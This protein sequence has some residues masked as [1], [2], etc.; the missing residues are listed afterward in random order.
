ML[1]AKDEND[2]EKELLTNE[3]MAFL[4]KLHRRFEKGMRALHEKQEWRASIERKHFLQETKH[5]REGRWNIKPV[6]ADLQDRRVVVSHSAIDQEKVLSVIK[7]GASLFTADFTSN[8]VQLFEN[9]ICS[10]YNLKQLI[11][12]DSG[13]LT[14]Y[15]T[16]FMII[17]RRWNEQ[18]ENIQVGGETMSAGLFDFG[19]YVFH[20][21]TSLMQQRSA[22]Y[23][24]LKGLKTYQEAMFWNSV[25]SFVEKEMKLIEGTIK[26]SVLIRD[27]NSIYELE[28]V[29]YELR[30]HCA[31]IHFDP[32]Q[33]GIMTDT[34]RFV[35][36]IGHKRN[37]HVI[38]HSSIENK[39]QKRES[40]FELGKLKAMEGF[41]GT[42]VTDANLVGV[43]K[44]IWNHYMPEPN[45][46][47]K[48]RHE[49]STPLVIVN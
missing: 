32:E 13:V 45:Q 5:I 46:I 37:T 7:E 23:V 25:F 10:Q 4:M 15:K 30:T 49:F 38:A 31:G 12:R 11:K 47:W 16:A 6:R 17:P 3:A 43:M 48:K 41:D 27:I 44:G 42:C 39:R 9:R 36:S 22:P 33:N 18:E 29:L 1:K 19:L 26:A 24:C 40:L 21:T 35:I 28:E 8:E 14:S 34:A 2:L 20:N